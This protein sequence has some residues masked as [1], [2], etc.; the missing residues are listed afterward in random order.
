MCIRDRYNYDETPDKNFIQLLTVKNGVVQRQ[1][2]QADYSLL[3]KTLARRTYDESGDYVVD[4]FDI[5]VRE[6]YNN[7]NSGVYS[8][9]ASGTVNNITPGEASEK[10]V[11]TIGPGKGYVRGYEIVNKE[12]KYVE[13]DKA[14]DTLVRDNVTIRSTGLSSFTL[15]NVY[16]TI[17]LN[18][19]GA[20]LTAYPTVYLNST[21]NDGTVGSNNNEADTDLAAKIK[22]K[23]HKSTH[24][25]KHAHT[26]RT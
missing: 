11:A 20:D 5:D 3:E 14:R 24:K 23:K 13:L 6:F 4:K 17:P 22:K 9:D 10:L 21:Y 8:L 26:T 19:E 16:N 2:K 25:Q 1:I 12:T 15:T 18:A 7:S